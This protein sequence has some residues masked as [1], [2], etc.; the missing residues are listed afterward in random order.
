MGGSKIA[1]LEDKLK[2]EIQEKR[3]RLENIGVS[4]NTAFSLLEK[5]NKQK[6]EVEKTIEESQLEEEK[7]IDKVNELEL[8]LNFLKKNKKED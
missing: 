4:K 7:I 6:L 8:I 2:L 5:I 1:M 3:K